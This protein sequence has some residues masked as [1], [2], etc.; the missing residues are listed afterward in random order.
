MITQNEIALHLIKEDIKYHKLIKHL[1]EMDV[2]IEF[3]PDISS[4]VQACIAPHLNEMETQEWHDRYVQLIGL[5]KE[6]EYIYE[7]LKAS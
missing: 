5:K 4:A 6:E 7:Q 3:Y 1:A 2:H